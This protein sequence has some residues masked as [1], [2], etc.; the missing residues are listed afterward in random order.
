MS[1]SAH[2]HYYTAHMTTD[3][4]AN[5][6]STSDFD[7]TTTIDPMSGGQITSGLDG[8]FDFFEQQGQDWLLQADFDATAGFLLPETVL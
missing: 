4:Y 6:N 1:A 5:T 8:D 7:F 3:S 2:D